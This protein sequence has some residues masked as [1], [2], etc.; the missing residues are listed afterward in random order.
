MPSICSVATLSP[1]PMLTASAMQNVP[2][3]VVSIMCKLT[4]EYFVQQYNRKPNVQ[5]EFKVNVQP[6]TP[7]ELKLSYAPAAALQLTLRAWRRCGI[8][9]LLPGLLFL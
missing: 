6:K 1:N 2:P 4:I 8:D 5:N 3:E 9:I 7:N